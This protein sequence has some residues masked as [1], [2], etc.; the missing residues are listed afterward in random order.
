M[1]GYTI[2][3]C[4]L[5]VSRQNV[6]LDVILQGESMLLYYPICKERYFHIRYM[7]RGI[8]FYSC[9]AFAVAFVAVG[10]KSNKDKVLSEIQKYSISLY[11]C[12]MLL[13][14]SVM[15]SRILKYQNYQS[16]MSSGFQKNITDLT[17]ILCQLAEISK[18]IQLGT[19][20]GYLM[21][22]K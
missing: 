22:R 10:Y 9:M 16:S 4:D 21:I 13:I 1:I 2:D 20:Y 7:V 12:Y 18:F 3:Y 14:D 17:R 15:K 11:I 6:F 5:F 19:S 8:C